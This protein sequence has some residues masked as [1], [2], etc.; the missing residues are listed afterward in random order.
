MIKSANQYATSDMFGVETKIK[1][2]IPKFQREYVWKKVDW[3]NLLDDLS[4]NDKGH[5][6]GSI[7]I[8][9]KGIDFLDVQPLEVIDG[10]QRLTTISLLYAAIYSKFLTETKTDED[11]VTEKNNL[12][13]RL[14]QKGSKNA[15]KL[16]LSYQNSNYDDYKAIL[17]ELHLY[18]GPNFKKPSNLGNRRIYKLY[19]YYKEKI[20]DNSYADLLGLLE[21]MNSSLFV[22]IEVDSH[23][24]AFN[25]FESLNNRG[26]PLSA[27]D[28]I[29]NKLLSELE[30]KKKATLDEAFDKWVTLTDS[31][32]DYATQERF[33]RQFYNAYRYR[34][35]IKIDGISKATRSTLIKIYEKLIDRNV[36]LIFE[37][38][39]SKAGVYN[40]FINGSNSQFSNL[41]AL[42]RIGAA[43]S[44][45]LLLYLF[46]E[47]KDRT[48][49]LNTTVDFLIKY[50]V[51]R[52]LT[53]FPATR[54][55]DNMFMALIDECE[56]R[57]KNLSAD[58][59]VK[60]MT[61]ADRFAPFSTFKEKLEGDIYEDNSDVA[62]FILCKIEEEHQTKE[63]H[64]DLWEKDKNDKYL[65]TIEHIFPEGK[66]IPDNWVS[67][68]ASGDE[69]KAKELQEKWVHKI[70]NLTITAYNS[71]LS[72]FSFEKKRDRKDN[73]GKN[74][75]YKNGLY[76]N[77][78][79]DTDLAQ[80]ERWQ[81][82]DIEK[83][84]E[85]LTQNALKLFA[86]DKE[87]P[88]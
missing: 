59:I 32:P 68:I 12:K 83:R 31:L 51:R 22:K 54:D 21:K 24:D 44:Y 7:I 8:I 63:I 4:E 43:P 36:I 86:L 14:I 69:K 47:Y 58:M 71:N 65:W 16:E 10:Q 53:D 80:K 33:L 9:N 26:I 25:L 38:L 82:R 70:G 57:K 73:K 50:F 6:L 41:Q 81:I 72:N 39:I 61:H 45:T 37:E 13:Y 62:R 49:L 27:M 28:L 56:K 34:N 11:F 77:T 52:N 88:Y 5:F 75:G 78:D 64:R 17:H 55:L 46:S 66:N 67:M 87:Q 42:S 3:D 79:L 74:I 84:T 2:V 18:S 19:Q 35:Q 60:Y 29:K 23:A 20:S 30:K 76:L 15:V 40:T 85:E 1:Y 48:D